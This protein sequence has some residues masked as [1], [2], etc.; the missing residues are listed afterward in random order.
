MK[1]A[2]AESE[3]FS[4]DDKPKQCRAPPRVINAKGK[5]EPEC[6]QFA[7]VRQMAEKWDA[8]SNGTLG[9]LNVWGADVPKGLHQIDLQGFGLV[10]GRNVMG[11]VVPRLLGV[12]FLA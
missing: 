10:G 7:E 12:M 3:R 6:L 9:T 4:S 11:T 5:E 2:I 8:G 1:A